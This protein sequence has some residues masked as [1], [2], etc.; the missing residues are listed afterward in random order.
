MCLFYIIKQNVHIVEN[1]T[2]NDDL[3]LSQ[4]VPFQKNELD[5]RLPKK[6]KIPA[7][8]L[9]SIVEYVGMTPEGQMDVPKSQ[10]NVAWYNLGARPG[11]IGSAV[12]A[13]HYGWLAKKASVF[14]NLYKLRAGDKI[15]V[16]D[17]DGTIV[18]F[19]VRENRRY[20]ENAD[21]SDVFISDDG[22]A[23]LNLVAC[24]GEWNKFSKSYPSRLVVFAD[25][26]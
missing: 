12:I 1:K 23:H 10:D 14:D 7:I 20:S 6:L 3:I 11:D 25:K 24:E 5:N 4:E 16:E 19:V 21:A 13:G 15:F 17:N 8:G 2:A 18:T 26:E 9:E 22:K